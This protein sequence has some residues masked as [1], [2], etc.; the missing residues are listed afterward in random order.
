MQGKRFKQV[1]FDEAD[2]VFTTGK[3]LPP[4]DERFQIVLNY[5]KNTKV[6]ISGSTEVVTQIL[7]RLDQQVIDCKL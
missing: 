6:T 5:P 1:V 2:R 4:A 3:E 7:H